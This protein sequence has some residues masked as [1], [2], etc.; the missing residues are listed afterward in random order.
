[1]VFVYDLEG[2]HNTELSWDTLA[3]TIRAVATT[4][5]TRVQLPPSVGSGSGSGSYALDWAASI[6]EHTGP[7]E[8]W[9]PI[10]QTLPGQLPIHLTLAEDLVGLDVLSTLMVLTSVQHHALRELQHH[11]DTVVLVVETPRKTMYIHTVMIVSGTILVCGVLLFA[12]HRT[13]RLQTRRG[14][15]GIVC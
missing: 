10:H 5:D 8:W 14:P 2:L 11:R 13:T 12:L 9:L 6:R 4:T 1:M 15:P 3:D 7:V